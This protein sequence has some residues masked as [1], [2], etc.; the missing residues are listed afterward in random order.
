MN[1]LNVLVGA[2]YFT[3]LDI[4]DAYHKIRV[5]AGD[6]WKTAFRCRYGKIEYWVMPFGLVN[7]PASF[8]AYINETLRECL[9]DF[10]V[11]Y[12]D[13]ILVFSKSMKDHTFHVRLVLDVTK[14]GRGQGQR[15]GGL[16]VKL[17]D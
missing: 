10:V 15:Q 13:D 7:A 1:L 11:V 8:Q 3:K 4:R 14:S 2:V 16:M 5:R 17:I 6:E 9:D 12:L